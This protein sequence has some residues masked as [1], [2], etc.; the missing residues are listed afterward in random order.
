MD[1]LL[2][3]SDE[4][5]LLII[6]KL[7]ESMIKQKDVERTENVAGLSKRKE[8]EAKLDELHV[9]GSLRRL[10]GAAPF[11]DEGDDWKKEKEAYLTSKYGM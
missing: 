5:K 2:H 11:I 3:Q 4:I 7:S 6:N 9:T 1:E 8:I 10:F